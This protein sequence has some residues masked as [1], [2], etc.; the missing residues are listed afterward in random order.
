MD[1]DQAIQ[2]EIWP[3]VIE[4]FVAW[5]EAQPSV[6]VPPWR[7]ARFLRSDSERWPSMDVI[8]TPLAAVQQPLEAEIVDIP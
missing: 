7:L 5:L 8:K 6:P 2:E 1:E 3:Q 4:F